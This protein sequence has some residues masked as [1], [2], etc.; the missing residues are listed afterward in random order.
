MDCVGRKSG[1]DAVS[2]T[3]A[4]VNYRYSEFISIDQLGL[5]DAQT[6]NSKLV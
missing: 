6:V 3:Y 1:G 4:A 2:E 5:I